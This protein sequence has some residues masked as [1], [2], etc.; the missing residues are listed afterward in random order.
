[1]ALL[2]LI[3]LAWLYVGQLATSVQ[4]AGMDMTGT[5]IASTGTRMVMT[6]ILPHWSGAEFAFMFLMWAVMMVA[7]MLPSATP[8]VL[9]YARVGRASP[10]DVEPVGPDRVVC[11]WL[12]ARMVRICVC[13]HRR[14]MG[15]WTRR[16]AYTDGKHE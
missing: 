3:L 5:R 7:M 11:S 15:T 10:L 8:M 1:M 16:V 12:S 13:R 2:I 6:S 4:M 9:R 14:T